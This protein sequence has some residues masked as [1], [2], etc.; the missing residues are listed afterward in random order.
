MWSVPCNKEFRTRNLLRGRLL[1]E[2]DAPVAA[3]LAG[4]ELEGDS[5]L[6]ARFDAALPAEP[7]R[8]TNKGWDFKPTNLMLSLT[9][10]CQLACDYCYIRGGDNPRNMPWEVT[11]SAIRFVAGNAFERG[12]WVKSESCWIFSPGP[13]PLKAVF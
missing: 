13:H 5:E 3:C 8:F 2:T 12:D 11:E 6:L 4:C 1:L 7:V 9:A 10:A